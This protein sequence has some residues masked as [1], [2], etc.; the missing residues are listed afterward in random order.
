MKYL[1]IYYIYIY[2]YI[3]ILKSQIIPKNPHGSLSE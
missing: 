1:L 2:I 3:E